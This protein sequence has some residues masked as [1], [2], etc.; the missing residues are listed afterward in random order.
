VENTLY[1]I[2]RRLVLV[3]VEFFDVEAADEIGAIEAMDVAH[4]HI[5]KLMAWLDWS[6]WVRC[7][8][9][10]SLGVHPLIPSIS[11]ARTDQRIGAEQEI[12][13]IPSWPYFEED[14]L[15]DLTPHCR[16]SDHFAR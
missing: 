15:Y 5:N 2:C 7:E 14:D 6:V 8:P 3:W 16:S 10:C 11:L 4:G 12:C 13:Y 1:E 9:S